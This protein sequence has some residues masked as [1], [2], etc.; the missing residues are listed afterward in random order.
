MTEVTRSGRGIAS[1]P[2]V[3][4]TDEWWSLVGTDRVP[5]HSQEGLIDSVFWSGHNDFAEF[6]LVAAD[7]TRHDWPRWGDHTL[8]V[9]GLRAR[10][11]WVEQQWAE[12]ER[13]AFGDVSGEV[14]HLCVRVEVEE[15]DR[16]SE[17]GPP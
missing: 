5:L 16:R 17:P 6:T 9:E 12:A 13:R 1:E 3:V 4:G 14:T 15:S 7:G 11:H 10:M 2:A 8:Y